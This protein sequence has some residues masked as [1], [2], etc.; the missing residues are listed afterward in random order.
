VTVF[1]DTSALVKRYADEP[2]SDL[3]REITE[4]IVIASIARVEL[5]AALWR[6]HRM[7]ELAAEDVRL[8]GTQ[9]DHDHI[10]PDAAL[11]V[12]AV[13]RDTFGR[14]ATLVSRHPLRAYDAVQLATALAVDDAVGGCR[15]GCFDATLADAAS[16][17]GLAPVWA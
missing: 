13:D 16:A 12:A 6:K 3:V 14:A 15:F 17:E 5:A 9:F 8:L 1:L 2:G 4:V 11:V 7:G 10:G